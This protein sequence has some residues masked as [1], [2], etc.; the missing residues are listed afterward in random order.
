MG[1]AARRERRLHAPG[2]AASR[3][4]DRR[5]YVIAV[6]CMAA[7]GFG[8]LQAVAGVL[9]VDGFAR[10]AAPLPQGA[11]PPVT[12]LK[13]V[14]GD[15]PG[16]AAALSS[17][18]TQDYPQFQV[19]IG[20]QA[21]DDPALAVAAQLRDR[22]PA[23]D[24]TIVTDPAI[25]GPNRKVG[26][27]INMLPA[28]R[29]EVLV[30]ADSDLHVRPDYLRRVVAALQRPGVG[31]VTTVCAGEAA[32]PGLVAKL[33]A[34]HLSYI[35]LPGA[36]L[37][38]FCRQ[39]DCL[40]G[41]MALR[42]ETLAAVGGLAA[43]VRHLADDNVLGQ[44]V[45]RLGLEVRLAATLPVVTAQETSAAALWQHE[46]R[47]ART[48]RALAPAAYA[49]STLQFP[50]FWAL[51]GILASGGARLAIAVFLALWAMRAA[52]AIGIEHR[53]RACRARP[54]AP[55]Q[56]WL[57]PLRDLLSVAEVVASFCG[58]QVVWRG[59]VMRASGSK[60]GWVGRAG[61]PRPP[62]FS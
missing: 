13:P 2:I 12:L 9:A 37:A 56:V 50:L 44:L 11:W 36:L 4:T 61:P 28:A 17:F 29:H 47:W 51:L 27:L 10:G 19:V 41:T 30:I 52:V 8:A 57:L 53:L 23:C 3:H 14:C 59:H 5:K 25:H 1:T 48:I 26:N 33:G 35:F 6:V 21:A 32:V 40:G 55:V 20:A 16:L 22:F 15:E 54:A 39:Q 49:A 7:A 43:L 45:R 18:C 62:G 34:M 24:L 46:M 42:R 60:E 31:L 38:G 58:N